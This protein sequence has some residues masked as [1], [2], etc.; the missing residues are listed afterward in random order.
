MKYA[1]E[2]TL[3]IP[4]PHT[5]Y[6]E[7]AMRVGDIETPLIDC[8]LPSWAP[9]S[10][11]IRDFAKNV[12]GF[13]AEGFS[14]EKIAK[15]TWRVYTNGATS[16]VIRYKVYAFE[17]SVQTNH[18]DDSH[19]HLNGTGLFM[20]VDGRKDEPLLLRISRPA[21]WKIATGL[22]LVKGRS[23]CF[24][25]PGYD[26]LV[27]CPIEIGECRQFSFRE[28]GKLHR[29]VIHGGGNYD[30][31]RMA[32]DVR[33]IVATEAAMFGGV[34]Y[35]HYTFF[36][37]T[38]PGGG[39]GLEHLN[40]TS[41]IT[42]P[43]IFQPQE[44]Y[45]RF[46]SLVAHEFFH[47][48]NVKRIRPYVLGPFDYRS[49]NYTRLLYVM[50]GFTSYYDTL[51]LRRARL[52]SAGNYLKKVAETIRNYREKPGRLVQPLAESS[53]DTWIKLY[54]PNE[55]SVN[56]QISYYEKGQL[57]GLLLDLEI[58]KST[59]N[60]KSLDD[61]MRLLYRRYAVKAGRGFPEDG[62]RRAA[63]EVA[64]NY[65][66]RFFRD[67]VEGT[68]EL[69]FETAL[70]SAGLELAK[71]PKKDK[72]G[73]P[74]PKDIPNLGIKVEKK[75]EILSITNVIKE[76]PAYRGGI[77]AWDELVAID[78]CKTDIENWQ[79]RIEEKPPRGRVAITVFRRGELRTIDVA[80]VPK[81]NVDYKIR[82]MKAA[83]RLQKAIGSS[84]LRETWPNISK[85][86]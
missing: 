16:A 2:Y 59:A 65:L 25:A 79:K 39:G 10:Y 37:H 77:N 6:V 85:G 54:Q 70:N 51:I 75:G 86:R 15:D 83:T 67:W 40:S 74:L 11:K 46:L 48:W 49:E 64:G 1:I 7:I 24:E 20:Y 29:F 76:T 17:L 47:L 18:V 56:S 30:E 5:H 66:R 14:T 26:I 82:C 73:K 43:F 50:E 44:K 22:E 38:S 8:H 81:E 13:S 34:P 42:G 3:A 60:R 62:F 4:A 61:V 23:N 41:L 35:R 55:N 71:E 52:I 28:R 72:D 36:L 31:K 78:G 80:L 58:R 45:E 69:D 53:F 12:E 21:G 32:R 27:D 9:G 68:K 63:E 33:K 84:W 57:V 19:A